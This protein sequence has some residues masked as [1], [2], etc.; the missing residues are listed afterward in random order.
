MLPNIPHN[1][2]NSTSASPPNLKKSSKTKK[3]GKAK[4]LFKRWSKDQD[5]I[6]FKVLNDYL[7]N[8]TDGTMNQFFNG[9]LKNGERQ[10]IL[11]NISLTTNWQ[12]DSSSLFARLKKV[13]NRAGGMSTR[14]KKNLKKITKGKHRLT[15]ADFNKILYNFPGMSLE[16]LKNHYHTSLKYNN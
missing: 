7:L 12:R 9:E 10:K 5:K 16:Q 3:T 1:V 11:A 8:I 6:A 14:E 13:F 4:S 2:E 15:T